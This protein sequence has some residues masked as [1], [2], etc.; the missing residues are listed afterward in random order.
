MSGPFSLLLC[1]CLLG[2]K[3]SFCNLSGV[4]LT[5]FGAV[6]IGYLDDAN[7]D[8][9]EHSTLWGDAL[10]L[11]SA[12]VYG[13]YVVFIKLKIENESSVNMFLFFAGIGAINALTLW[14]FL[15]ILDAL[16]LEAFA[17]PSADILG[18]LTL[19]GLISV[20][21]DY[22]W[23]Q[24]ILFTSP[25]VATVGL[26]MMMPVAMIADEIFRGQRHSALYWMGSLLVMLGFILVNLD[27]KQQQ[28]EEQE[29]KENTQEKA[30]LNAQLQIS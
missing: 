17:W 6:F 5:L 25:V 14:P 27:F 26:S 7:A 12:F 20:G 3:L 2:T 4:L 11:I 29:A 10:A 16:H 1:R 28:E 19:N 22:F 21:R 30:K 13:C 24:S 8:G 23:A 9:G 15:F 18:L